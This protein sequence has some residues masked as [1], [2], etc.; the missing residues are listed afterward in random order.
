SSAASDVYKRQKIHYLVGFAFPGSNQDFKYFKQNLIHGP[1]GIKYGFH[2]WRKM[3]LGQDKAGRSWQKELEFFERHEDNLPELLRA[4]LITLK[5]SGEHGL[6][7]KDLFLYKDWEH[8]TLNNNFAF[9]EGD[10]QLDTASSHAG[11]VLA[12][13]NELL[14]NAR[15]DDELKSDSRLF[16]DA[17]QHAVLSPENY[18]RFNDGIIQASILRMGHQSELDYRDSEPLSRHMADTII[19]SCKGP[20]PAGAASLEFL[21]ALATQRVRLHP[22]ATDLLKST[23]VDMPNKTPEQQFFIEFL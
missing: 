8:F 18:S 21:L 15:S 10:A 12:S 1:D 9:W 20:G 5:S 11:A 17:Y 22:K 3:P 4:R 16:S 7:G 6:V 19:M 23:F 2:F 14:N 13:I